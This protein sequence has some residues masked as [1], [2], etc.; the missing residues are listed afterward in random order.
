MWVGISCLNNPPLNTFAKWR[1]PFPSIFISNN[2]VKICRQFVELTTFFPSTAHNA[3]WKMN[4]R[5]NNSDDDDD[6]G[7]TVRLLD[8]LEMHILDVG[9][10]KDLH[11][12]N[13]LF[14]FRHYSCYCCCCNESDGIEYYACRVMISYNANKNKKKLTY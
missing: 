13:E 7:I 12:L 4:K 9:K 11:S 5:H 14:F 1:L 6:D 10:Q 3:W 2:A 8:K